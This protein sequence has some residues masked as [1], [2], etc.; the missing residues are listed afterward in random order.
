MAAALLRGSRILG[1]LGA[2]YG[3][4][5]ASAWLCYSWAA[6][7]SGPPDP[8]QH[9]FHGL[10]L[11]TAPR[12]Q[13]CQP[14]LQQQATERTLARHYQSISTAPP[15]AQSL[16]PELSDEQILRQLFTYVW[17]KDNPEF[18]RRVSGAL[19]LLLASKICN[20]QVRS[21]RSQLRIETSQIACTCSP[22]RCTPEGSLSVDARA[23][24]VRCAPPTV[25]HGRA[26]ARWP[27]VSYGDLGQVPARVH[28]RS[29]SSPSVSS[30]P[31]AQVPF[32]FKYTV[33][34]LADPTAHEAHM[35]AVAGVASPIALL[36]AYGCARAGA[37]LASELR[38]AVFAKVAQGTIRKVGNQVR[39]QLVSIS[40][41]FS[42]QQNSSVAKADVQQMRLNT[43]AAICRC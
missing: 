13:P 38:N 3:H 41:C 35:L 28:V 33:D 27:C 8:W 42:D 30:A 25:A 40:A 12:C 23:S 5:N 15:A 22:V 34:A 18:K 17:P 14:C 2:E 1:R 21:L 20:I 24:R 16:G 6:P 36:A 7:A 39:G 37:T 19:V 29:S 9:S 4:T 32:L 26:A 43:C 11:Q 31:R 10:A